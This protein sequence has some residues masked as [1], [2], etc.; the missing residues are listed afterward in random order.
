MSSVTGS[1]TFPTPTGPHRVGRIALDLMDERRP[2]P[3]ARRVAPRRLAVWVWYPAVPP[4]SAQP[5][6]YLPGW[7]GVLGPVWGF[8]PSRVRVRSVDD[9]PV[10]AEAGALPLLIFSP[11][12]NPP[13]FY[14][15][16]FEE[17]A[18]H[19][20]L[21]AGIAHTYETIPISAFPDGGVRLL[22]P[23]SL[24]GAF[25]IPGKRPY[26][27]D[28]RERAGLIDVKT[29][30]IRFVA[31]E[32]ARVNEEHPVLGGRLDLSRLG[33]LGHSFGGAAAAEVCR[34]D[35]RF[36]TGASIDGGLWKAP[37]AVAASGPFLQLFG[38]HPEYVM[39]CAD[40]VN[41]KYYANTDYCATDRETTIGAWQ[42]LHERARPGHSV[43][44]RGA[45]HASFI[46]WPL[47]PLW[48]VSM[49]RRGLGTPPPG[50]VWRVTSDYLLDFFG[51]HLLG[52]AASRTVAT[53][54]DSY[55]AVGSPAA[56]FSGGT[57]G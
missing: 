37:D 29:A 16:L 54:P 40:A 51:E 39:R 6:S 50:V 53:S 19:G 13:H 27:E 47:L 26:A 28:L 17:L 25:S 22:N 2:D 42:A 5:G 56:L 57:A 24:G 31:D 55:V 3:Y 43:L 35:E 23:K 9:S 41:A 21:V 36:R 34:L 14:T 12:G 4:E 52:R 1:G 32:L 45:G 46:D 48:R 10:N 20:Y 30:D 8:R 15:A 7:W 18:S 33:A 44:V 38:E 49:A 11:S